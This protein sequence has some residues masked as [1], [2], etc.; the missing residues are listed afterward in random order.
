MSNISSIVLSKFGYEIG[1]HIPF[2][3]TLAKTTE[4]AIKMGMY[5]FQIFLGSPQSFQITKLD[6]KDI[7]KCIE[8][9]DRFPMSI[10]VHSPYVLNLAGSK[11]IL[12][13][14]EDHEQ[15]KKTMMAIKS[16]Q[17]QLNQV[18][19][20]GR[21]VVLHPG[22]YKNKKKGCEAIAKSISKIEFCENANLILENMAGQGTVIGSML[23]ELRD[24]RN[25]VDENKRKYITFCIDTA[26]I[27]GK[28]LY[29]L[30][31]KEDIDKMFIDIEDILGW[32][33]VSLFHL[34][35]SMV[36]CGA[37]VDRH[38][39]LGEGEIWKNNREMLHYLLE[40][41]KA[42]NISCVMETDPSDMIKFLD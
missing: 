21:G 8:M 33:N 37:C 38:E 13:W 34:N 5:T 2:Q 9:I 17:E 29:N 4:F 7:E 11:D 18:S 28:G 31:K 27:W 40:R 19:L 10:F 1:A 25:M 35:D 12:A 32:E 41:L 14:E 26:H 39:L 15:D 36:K 22:T 30:S 23:E 3:K 42:K 16:L 20:F 24:I 6:K